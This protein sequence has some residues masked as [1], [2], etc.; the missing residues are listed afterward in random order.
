M[1]SL[2]GRLWIVWAAIC[3][4]LPIYPALA[5]LGIRGGSAPV[6]IRG[7]STPIDA[8]LLAGAALAIGVLSVA[9][10]QRAILGPLDSGA[11]DPSSE[12]GAQQILARSVATWVLA[13]AV[14]LIGF[15]DWFFGGSAGWLA[16]YCA[17]ALALLVLHA[18]RRRLL[19]GAVGADAASSAE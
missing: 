16:L 8:S 7:G 6:G 13:D 3:A 18:P 19:A 1:D 5:A 12:R 4:A 15:L 9:L 10:R 11:L 14:A 2:H 17:G